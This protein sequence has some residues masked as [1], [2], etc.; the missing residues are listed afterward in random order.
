MPS[1]D[2]CDTDE[3]CDERS[4][5]YY[6]EMEDECEFIDSPLDNHLVSSSSTISSSDDSDG[7]YKVGPSQS[8]IPFGM[9]E[10]ALRFSLPHG[11]ENWNHKKRFEIAYLFNE[12]FKIHKYIWSF[13]KLDEK[14][15]MFNPHLHCYLI[16]PKISKST[17]SDFIKSINHLIRTDAKGRTMTNAQDELKKIKNYKAYIIKDGDYITNYS[18][19]EIEEIEKIKDDIQENQ[20]LR[21]EDKLL[22]IIQDKQNKLDEAYSKLTQDEKDINTKKYQIGDLND[23]YHLILKIYCLE[24]KKA[25]PLNLCKNYAM[26]VGINMGIEQALRPQNV[27]WD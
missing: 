18:E 19:E 9:S 4:R 8:D 11:A 13:E 15:K 21:V 23:I 14:D 20:R 27:F 1:D 10:Y 5:E 24:W 7:S 3:Y 26:Y 6:L 22:Q 12:K 17:K 2:E 25:P 16:S